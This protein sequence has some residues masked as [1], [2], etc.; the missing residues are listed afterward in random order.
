MSHVSQFC[1]TSVLCVYDVGVKVYVCVCDRDVRVGVC[2]YVCV[3][4]VGVGVYVC[5]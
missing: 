5:M 3:Y 4:D 2:M 1:S